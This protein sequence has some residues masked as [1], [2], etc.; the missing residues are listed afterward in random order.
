MGHAGGRDD[1]VDAGALVAAPHDDVVA[2][3]EQR[4]QRPPPGLGRLPLE[5][6]G[7]LEDVPEGAADPERGRAVGGRRVGVHVEIEPEQAAVHDVGDGVVDPLARVHVRQRRPQDRGD[8]EA[9]A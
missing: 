2:D 7:P 6:V 8:V 4:R 9:S 5:G 1:V 3:L